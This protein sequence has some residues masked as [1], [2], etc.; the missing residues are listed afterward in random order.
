MREGWR[1]PLDYGGASD[2]FRS[3]ATETAAIWRDMNLAFLRRWPSPQTLGKSRR[4]TLK[5]FPH[6]HGSR[7]QERCRSAGASWK[8]WCLCPPP[9]RFPTGSKSSRWRRCLTCSM[10]PSGAT[11]PPLP[12]SSNNS[13]PSNSPRSRPCPK[14][15][16][17][18]HP[19]VPSPRRPSPASAPRPRISLPRSAAPVTDQSGKM[20]KVYRR[21]RC[22]IHMRRSGLILAGEFYAPHLPR[23]HESTTTPP[24]VIFPCH[25]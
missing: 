1:S 13:P 10:R 24:G 4:S 8:T 25:Q 3:V 17:P 12:N 9:N 11:T 18:S 2:H 7:S 15:A 22:H 20:K 23:P 14:P 5:A 21:L 6:Q 19:A 16:P